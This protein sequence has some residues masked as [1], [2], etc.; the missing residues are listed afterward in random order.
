MVR[1]GVPVSEVS[2]VADACLARHGVDSFNGSKGWSG[3]GIG[4]DVHEE[5]QVALGSDYVLQA[6]M[7]LSLEPSFKVPGVGAF[8]NEQNFVVTETGYEL[9]SPSPMEMRVLR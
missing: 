1:P 4:L 7:T 5:P 9:L 3:H 8:C 2:R 6:G